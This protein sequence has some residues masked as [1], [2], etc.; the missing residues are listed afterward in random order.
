MSNE[1]SPERDM[2]ENRRNFIK[3]SIP[4]LKTLNEASQ[5]QPTKKV[6]GKNKPFSRRTFL[7]VSAAGAAAVGLVLAV[8]KVLNFDTN[9]AATNL[10]YKGRIT[11][12]QRRAAAA[13]RP[14]AAAIQPSVVATPGGTPDYFGT[15][16]NYANSPMPTVGAAATSGVTL[17]GFAIQSGG[18]NYTTPVVV[19]TGGAGTG[20][21]ATA[22]VSNGVIYGITLTNPGAGY[23][24]AP[25]VSFNDPNP[26]ASGAAATATFTSLVGAP[27]ITGGIRKFV[28]GLPG[29]GSA[30]A[31][32]LGQYLPVAVPDTTTYPGCDYYIIELRQYTEKMHSDLPLTTLRGY[33]QVNSAGV[34]VA[35]IHYMGPIIVANRDRP[36]RVKF[37]NKLPTGSG[38]NL[39]IPCDTTYMG[40]GAGPNG[41]VYTQN[42]SATHL[43]GG[44]TI[45]ISDGTPHQW[46]TPAGESTNYPVGVSVK[47]IPDMDGGV[48]PQG[49]LTFFYSNQQS[50]RLMFY[51]DHAV[52]ITRLN[53]YVGMAA[54]Y[55]V[56]DQFEK[57]YINGTNLSGANPTNA[58][59]LPDIGIPL[60]IQD[61]TFVDATTIATQDP[62]WNWGTT[63]P[64]PHTG[65]LWWPHVYMPNQNPYVT[66]GANP[67]GRWD[68]GPWFWPPW[69][70][71]IPPATNPYYNPTSAPWEPPVIPGTPNPSGTPESFMD[72]PI[73]NGTAYPYLTVQPRL[74]RFRILNACNDRFI[75]LQIYQVSNIINT[76]NLT[77]GGSGYT[78]APSVT[79]SGG[80][81]SGA[82]AT[83]TITGGAVTGITLVSVGSGYTSVPTVTISPP[84]GTGVTATATATI[85]T[86]LTEVGMLP[87]NVGAWPA[88]YP[89][90]DGRAGGFPDP[91]LRGPAIIQIGTEGGFLPAPA[92]ITNRPVGYDYNRRSI[93]VLN[94][95]EKAV[96]LGPAERADILVDFTNFSG[97]TLILYNDAPAPVPAFDPRIDYFT[98][99]GDQTSTGGAPNTIPGYGP[100][101]RTVMQFRVAAGGSST[102]PPNDYNPASLTA[103]T[104]A[105][106]N[107]FRTSQDTIIIPQA[108]YNAAYGGNFPTDMTAYAAI[109]DTTHV[110]TPIGQTTP[111]TMPLLPKG[112]QELFTNDYGRMNALLSYEIPNTN[113][114]IQTTIIQGYV[115]PPNE[116]FGYTPPGTLIGAAGDGTQLWKF[117][118]NGVDTHAMHFHL[119]NLQLI[120]RVGWDG[121][122]KPP[123]D[124]ELGW[125]ETI[126]MNPL[127]DIIVALRPIAPTNHPFKVPNSVRLLA[128]ANPQGSTLDFTNI[129]PL[130]NPVT[131]TNQL[132]NFGW[133]YVDHCHLLGHEE[134]DMMRPMCFVMPPEAPTTLAA[135]VVSTGI[136]LT[137]V[138]VAL[139]A[140]GITIQRATNSAFTA[141]LVTFTVASTAT[142]YI[143]TTA[144]HGVPYYYRVIA[145]NTVGVAIGA[146]PTMTQNSTPSNTVPVTRP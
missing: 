89:T 4:G 20:A 63:P 81:G 49:T 43:H 69:T 137:W 41:G 101:T 127:E 29:L 82:L 39:F 100:N 38:G 70:V 79:I 25:T 107:V 51:H 135:S 22:K 35:P 46:T 96:M 16:P 26:R 95:L 2:S 136:S 28:D 120:N 124:N 14:N 64:T 18:S 68:Y 3:N 141:N 97:K 78:S 90:A 48:E 24:S 72:T 128:P 61:R 115:D 119:F 91:A 129:D 52:G 21:T 142:S 67:C 74:Y 108:P 118:H 57:D 76:I 47:Q 10:N 59:I 75:N 86:G 40:A 62:T 130:G 56:T 131:I 42:R 125:K 66:S 87:A 1:K 133:E 19:L 65:D 146:Y 15:T 105:L 138:N 37:T 121:A 88:D 9:K 73:V 111:I 34:P 44:N 12:A 140:T 50:A 23:T 45:W 122:I 33:V 126:Q 99:D 80:G 7:K 92:L 117:T 85:Y 93:T 109:Q 31:N 17:N 116:I 77:G 5:K 106:A 6:L 84:G 53:V 71:T 36:V 54:G 139:N 145:S 83:A 132:V 94:V 98:G 104:T 123:A 58:V 113:G 110:F 144:A 114:T 134:N 30:N 112:I 13:A 8:P 102:A 55:L 60:V 27:I 11:P 32:N 103:L 143:D